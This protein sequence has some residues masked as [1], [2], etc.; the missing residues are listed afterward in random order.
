MPATN[1]FPQ[2]KV[3]EMLKA[4]EDRL[5]MKVLSLYMNGDSQWYL[6]VAI[7]LYDALEEMGRPEKLALFLRGV[8]GQAEVPWRIVALLRDS[9]SNLTILVPEFALSGATHVALSADRLVMGPL[10]TLG[11]VDPQSTHPTLPHGPKGEP[12]RV[13]VQDLHEFIAFATQT[14]GIRRARATLRKLVPS[15]MSEVNPLAIGAIR[16]ASLLSRDITRRVLLT[17]KPT[18]SGAAMDRIADLLAERFWSHSFPIT[19]A[20]ARDEIG[21]PVED[22]SPELWNE[23]MTVLRLLRAQ[24]EE[25]YTEKIATTEIRAS[26]FGLIDTVDSRWVYLGRATADGKA[27][28]ALWMPNSSKAQ[29]PQ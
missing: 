12:A 6:D 13:S 2:G 3:G 5:G 9:A 29:P 25:S 19:R 7:P 23:M 24:G 22:A 10:S 8:G 21:L 15:L 28:G 4:L 27:L 17:R 18:P 16:R 20:E 14:V 1:A 26:C 11:P